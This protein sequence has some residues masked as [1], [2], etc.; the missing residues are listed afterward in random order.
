MGRVFAYQAGQ[1]VSSEHDIGGA[2]THVA[3]V[4]QGR[5]L[6]L[7]VNGTRVTTSQLRAGPL[8]N[9][10]NDRPLLVG[11]GAQHYFSGAIADLR[12]YHGALG[13][14]AVREVLGQR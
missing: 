2:W 4:R 9:L 10:T 1:V 5:T 14:D 7:Y 3:A 11:F 8:F 13:T 6:K 12:L